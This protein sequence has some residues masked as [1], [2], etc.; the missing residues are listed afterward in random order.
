MLLTFASHQSGKTIGGKVNDC[1]LSAD[2]INSRGGQGLK[3]KT[4]V[5][6]GMSLLSCDATFFFAHDGMLEELSH[7]EARLEHSDS[8]AE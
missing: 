6:R 5:S 4:M 8:R 2:V 1:G 7:N 3:R